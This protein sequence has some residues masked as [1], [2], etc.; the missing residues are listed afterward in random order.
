M[1]VIVMLGLP[2]SGKSKQ[3]RLLAENGYLHISSS[4]LL[5]HAFSESTGSAK[6]SNTSQKMLSG[7]L[8][9]DDVIVSLISKKIHSIL[10]DNNSNMT[11]GLVF[12]GFPRTNNQAHKLDFILQ[13]LNLK[14]THAFLYKISND[15][16]KS[17]LATRDRADDTA[18]AINKRFSI[19]QD[20]MPQIIQKYSKSKCLYTIDAHKSIEETYIDT[21]KTLEDQPPGVDFTFSSVH[22]RLDR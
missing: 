3:A 21:I 5:T 6:N 20:N 14:V 4:G 17:R 2:G 8:I 19:F 16:C 1:R 15:V 9:Y 18:K 13:G 11:K 10:H 22:L 7:D 12:D